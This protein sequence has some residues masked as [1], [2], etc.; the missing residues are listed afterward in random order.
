MIAFI[1]EVW[2]A[3]PHASDGANMCCYVHNLIKQV[4]ALEYYTV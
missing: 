3:K 1:A 2:F 4:H